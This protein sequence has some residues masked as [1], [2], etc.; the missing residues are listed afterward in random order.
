M[1]DLDLEHE[2]DGEDYIVQDNGFASRSSWAQKGAKHFKPSNEVANGDKME[3]LDLESERDG[4]DDIVA[5]TGFAYRSSWAQMPRNQRKLYEYI[6]TSA[7][8]SDE[9]ANG[10]AMEDLEVENEKDDEDEIVQDFGFASR[11]SW[12][13]LPSDE[14]ANGD[15]KEDL[16]V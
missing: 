13:Q 12:V 14:V 15:E 3:D 8:P 10:D 6:Q 7:R 16:E 11:S 1:E 9:V 4:K 5:D 2:R